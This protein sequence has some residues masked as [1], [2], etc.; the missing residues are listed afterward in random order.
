MINTDYEESMKNAE[1]NLEEIRDMILNEKPIEK[2]HMI[3]ITTET[4]KRICGCCTYYDKPTYVACRHCMGFDK[5]E[6]KYEKFGM[7][8][9]IVSTKDDITVTLKMEE[10]E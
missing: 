10:S 8:T 7:N 5:F 3:G 2:C 9:T 4:Q 6:C 1:K